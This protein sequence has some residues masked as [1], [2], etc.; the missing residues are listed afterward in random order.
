MASFIHNFILAVLL[1]CLCLSSLAAQQDNRWQL[2]DSVQAANGLIKDARIDPLGVVYIVTDRGIIESYSA[3][4]NLLF[5]YSN[6]AFGRPSW[7][8]V[9]D[10]FSILVAYVEF[11]VIIELD[12]RLNLVRE[13]SLLDLGYLNVK[14]ACRS[15]DGNL[16]LYDDIL[17]EVIKLNLNTSREIIRSNVLLDITTDEQYPTQMLE[18]QNGLIILMNDG[19]LYLMD[20]FAQGAAPFSRVDPRV[21]FFVQQR[22]PMLVQG[23]LLTFV[24]PGLRTWRT[25]QLPRQAIWSSQIKEQ[26]LILSPTGTLYRYKPSK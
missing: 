25:V 16:W 12:N 14:L 7:I 11:G 26:L 17:T 23:E 20:A 4:G 2:I 3:Q 9:D 15:L 8:N 24:R 22:M 1:S 21:N 10:P 13:I 5:R 18:S 19:Q 6:L